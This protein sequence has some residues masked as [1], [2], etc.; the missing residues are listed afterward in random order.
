MH[1]STGVRT[2][3]NSGQGE[4]PD[5]LPVDM[6]PQQAKH[7]KLFLACFAK[8]GVDARRDARC[9]LGRTSGA[10]A[11]DVGAS[12]V[13]RHPNL[14]SACRCSSVAARPGTAVAVFVADGKDPNT[15]AQ[16]AAKTSVLGRRHP[17][18]AHRRRTWRPTSKRRRAA[19]TTPARRPGFVGAE[20]NR[21]DGH[22]RL[23]N[24]QGSLAR[25]IQNWP[26]VAKNC[27]SRWSSAE[28]V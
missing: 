20:E 19:W 5:L 28:R 3:G 4:D 2:A 26:C 25:R 27:A 22:P 13:A 8:T 21:L 6:T 1:E 9:V 15:T 10:R 7:N 12:V 14:G 23:S 17:D 24:R 18:S 11:G 16:V